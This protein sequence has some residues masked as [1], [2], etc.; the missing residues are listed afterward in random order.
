MPGTHDSFLSYD[1]E[2]GIP[3]PEKEQLYLKANRLNEY[4]FDEWI[5]P[6]LH[7]GALIIPA[8]LL[9]QGISGRDEI[10]SAEVIELLQR[11]Q[12]K[13]TETMRL[14]TMG[15]HPLLILMI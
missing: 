9:Q 12:E 2:T 8:H 14:Q 4:G 6:E 11:L 15:Q 10:Y 7:E 5:G 13:Q 3:I 1:S